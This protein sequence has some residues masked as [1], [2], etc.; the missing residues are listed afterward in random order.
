MPVGLGPDV[1]HVVPALLLSPTTYRPSVSALRAAGVP[2]SGRQTWYFDAG[3]EEFRRLTPAVRTEL[4][5]DRR[6]TNA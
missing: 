3:S 2:K 4:T 6:N 5:S 1:V